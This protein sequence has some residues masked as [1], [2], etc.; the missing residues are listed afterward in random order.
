[1]ER[2]RGQYISKIT[3]TRNRRRDVWLEKYSWKS[4]KTPNCSALEMIWSKNKQVFNDA[5]WWLWSLHV[6][7][8]TPQ[9]VK[10]ANCSGH[11]EYIFSGCYIK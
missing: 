5:Y 6:C 11:I 2:I 8:G 7:G 3:G 1:M 9:I 4:G 10:V